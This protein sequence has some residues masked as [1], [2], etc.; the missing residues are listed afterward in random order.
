MAVGLA[1]ALALALAAVLAF[2]PRA[3]AALS[4]KSSVTPLNAS[5]Y[6]FCS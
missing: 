5:C 3:L 1:L 2:S 6:H 4:L